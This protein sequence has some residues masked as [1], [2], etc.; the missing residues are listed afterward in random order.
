LSSFRGLAVGSSGHL[1]HRARP[2]YYTN[3][4]A[5]IYFWYRS[6]ESLAVLA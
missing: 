3:Y 1:I 5:V 6:F 4:Y 2:D